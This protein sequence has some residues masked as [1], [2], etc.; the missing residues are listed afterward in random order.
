MQYT[1]TKEADNEGGDQTTFS[2]R[3]S[4]FDWLQP[5]ISQWHPSVFNRI[6]KDKAL[7]LSVFQR[8]KRD[9]QPK[10]L[11]FIRIARERNHQVHHLHK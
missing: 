11:V 4:V 1:T 7:K 6:G 10:S 5:S 9:S 3:A 2:S 8:L